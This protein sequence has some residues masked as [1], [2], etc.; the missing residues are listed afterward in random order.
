MRVKI[1]KCIS[2]FVL[3]LSGSFALSWAGGAPGIGNRF[4][5]VTYWGDDRVAMIDLEGQPGAETVFDLDVLKNGCS[6]PYDVKVNKKGSRAY[7]TCSGAD[8]IIIID[9]VSQLVAGEIPSGNGPR[10]IALNSDET[11][12]ITSNSGE[13]TLSVI[14][15]PERRILY[16]VQG[17]G[18]QPYGVAL[19]QDEKI[20]VTTAWAS[21]EAYFIELGAT[22]G[23]VLGSVQVGAL[24]YTVIIPPGGQTAYVTVSATHSVVPIDIATRQVQPAISVGRNPWGAAPSADG[25][26]IIVANNRSNDISVLKKDTAKGPLLAEATRVA[27]GLGG[28]AGGLDAEVSRKAKNAA[29]SLDGKLG[30]FTDLANNELVLI[31]LTSGTLMQKSIAVGK[32]P[33]GLEFV[34]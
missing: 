17:V 22:S 14:S 34:R 5:M 20:A 26:T 9:I 23:K 10:D 11:L 13:D 1:L 31:D 25:N 6:K 29:L 3:F 24:P 33:Y 30:V 32:A 19:T 12:A 8:K 21:G 16:K 15:I 18:L 27:L 28:K 4:V 2:V 7:V